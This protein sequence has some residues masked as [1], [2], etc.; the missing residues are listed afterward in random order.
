MKWRR[1]AQTVT[2]D[3]VENQLDE[4]C[5]QVNVESGKLLAAVE[6]MKTRRKAG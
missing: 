2:T 5:E 4:A 3:K 1:R 6:A